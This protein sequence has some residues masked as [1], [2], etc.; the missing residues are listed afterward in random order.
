M[1]ELQITMHARHAMRS[2]H[3]LAVII[4][5]RVKVDAQVD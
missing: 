1:V 4:G 2:A 5:K 3:A